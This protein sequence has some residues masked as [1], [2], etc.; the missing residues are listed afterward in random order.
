MPHVS[1]QKI[2]AADD[3]GTPTPKIFTHTTAVFC[4]AQ[5]FTPRCIIKKEEDE[6][7]FC[8]FGFGRVGRRL[9]A[10]CSAFHYLKELQRLG[11]EKHKGWD[12]NEGSANGNG[13]GNIPDTCKSGSSI[14][15]PSYPSPPIDDKTKCI[16]PSN[17]FNS[18]K[19][20]L[21]RNIRKILGLFYSRLWTRH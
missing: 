3:V 2:S 11:Q 6:V 20:L 15:C 19:Y 14:S 7:S 4:L 9:G 17:S 5:P 18:V 1:L 12:E 13:V 10:C 21:K 8:D 16:T